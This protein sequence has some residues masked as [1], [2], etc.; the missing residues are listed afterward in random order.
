MDELIESQV[1]SGQLES[2]SRFSI[3]IQHSLSKGFRPVEPEELILLLVTWASQ[4]GAGRCRVRL[5]R[6]E[7]LVEHNGATASLAQLHE[8]ISTVSLG[9]AQPLRSLALAVVGALQMKPRRL[10]IEVPE[11]RWTPEGVHKKA[12][13]NNFRFRLQLPFLRRLGKIQGLLEGRCRHSSLAIELNQQA[14]NRPLDL[15]GNLA[16]LAL[17]SSQ[18]KLPDYRP[19]SQHE[20]RTWDECFSVVLGTDRG[21]FEIQIHGVGSYR[22]DHVGLAVSSESA[23]DASLLQPIADPQ[24]A[25][26]VAEMWLE[27]ALKAATQSHADLNRLA[28]LLDELVQALSLRQDWER[29]RP[30]LT[31]RLELASQRREDPI[32][33]L[34]QLARLESE[35]ARPEEALGYWRQAHQL[36]REVQSAEGILLCLSRRAPDPE[37]YKAALETVLQASH[38]S[39]HLDEI[40][41]WL[42]EGERWEDA[43]PCHR[44][45]LA[46]PTSPPLRARC[47]DRLILLSRRLGRSLDEENYRARAFEHGQAYPE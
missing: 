25:N 37:Q 45:W 6:S 40:C 19:A 33:W 36:R 42:W 4:S 35:C 34:H 17:H 7:L 24:L 23:V 28:E 20:E 15:S 27:L 32:G 11:G 38:K 12:T 5:T 3:D 39:Q 41:N 29:A 16:S 18:A 47:L 31:R 22:L 13:A 43:F 14:L 2:T 21:P 30:V 8:L 26:R 46:R 10:V 44:E 1:Q 9:S